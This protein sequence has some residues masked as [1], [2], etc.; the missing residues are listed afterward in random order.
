MTPS[1]SGVEDIMTNRGFAILLVVFLAESG[2]VFAQSGPSSEQLYSAGVQAFH[3]QRYADAVG[4]FDR[5][6]RLGAQDP[7]AFFFRGLS[8]SRSG[9]V[10][11]ATADYETAAAMELTV[12]GRTYSVPKAL[13]RIQGRE[14]MVIEQYRRAA[15]RVWEA[16]QNLR[17]QEDFLSQK[18]EDTK[19]Y[20]SIIESGKPG[21]SSPDAVEVS[22]L[23]LPFG[24]KPISPFGDNRQTFRP[25]VFT[26]VSQ[27]ELTQENMFKEDVERVTVFEKPEEPKPKAQPKPQDP[28]DKGIF[29]IDTD[30]DVQGFDVVFQQSGGGSSLPRNPLSGLGLSNFGGGDDFAVT[31]DGSDDERNSMFLPGGGVMNLDFGN[32]TGDATSTIP[33]ITSAK[34]SGRVFGKGFAS[35]FKKSGR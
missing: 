15:K 26:G 1:Q 33:T 31:S 24:A 30:D 5:I 32:E 7:R 12:A 11:A 16:E 6:E 25:R 9:N 14:R 17:K 13:E 29:D 28:T 10:A 22:D 23:T 18:S 35:W 21:T 8:H 27:G 4:F 19:F 20:Q 2:V 3:A 34:E